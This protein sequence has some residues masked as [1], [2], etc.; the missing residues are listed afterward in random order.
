MNRFVTAWLVVAAL[1]L[2]AS[3]AAAQY[4]YLDSNGN[5]VHDSGDKLATNGTATT[6]D[7]WIVTNHNRDGSVAD[8]DIQ[9]GDPLSINS[10]VVNLQAA[11]GLVSYSGFINRISQFNVAFGEFN[12]GDGLRYKNG[13]GG[14]SPLPPG[15]YRLATPP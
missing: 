9:P 12:P 10:Y 7:V 6:V 2:L 14:P 13:F 1:A 8:C 11:S 4:M 3:P 5:G 15:S